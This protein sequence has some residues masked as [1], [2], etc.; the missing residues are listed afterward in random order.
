MQMSKSKNKHIDNLLQDLKE[1]R[2]ELNCLYQVE[3]LLHNEQATLEELFKA[4]I[5]V[6]PSGWQFPE[7]A[8]VEI[9]CQGQTYKSSHYVETPR[10]QCAEIKVQDQVEGKVIVSYRREVSRTGDSY[11]LKEE[12]QLIKAIAERISHIL[13]HRELKKVYHQW[14]EAE[15]KLSKKAVGEWG[16]IVNLL[17]QSNP[18]LFMYLSQ[19]M[20]HYLCWNGIPEARNLMHRAGADITVSDPKQLVDDDP[21]QPQRRETMDNLLAIRDEVFKIAS[22]NLSDD[23]I[24]YHIRRWMEEEKS[25][26]LVEVLENP[27]TSLTDLINAISRFR[28][29]ETEGIKLSPPIDKSLRV[30]LVR[31]FLSEQLEFIRVAKNYIRIKDY[32]DLVKRMIFPTG[33]HGR[34]GGK[35]AGL[36]LATNICHSSTD[37][38]ELF[39]KIKIP[40]TWYITSDGLINFLHYNNL[41]GVYEQKYKEMDEIHVEYPNIIQIFKNAHFPS[42]MI[43]GLSIAVDDLGDT[44]IIVRSSSLLE[45]R[46]GAAFSGKYKSLFLANQGS[47][48]ERL[49]AL[50]DAIAE[51]YASTFG[52]DPIEYR[53]ERGLLDFNEEM[54]IMIQ[55][56]VGTRVGSYYLPTFAGVAFS[57]NEF[58]WS[59]RITREDGLIRL[60]PGLG[61]RA[62]DRVSDDYPILIAPGKPEL[63]VNVTPDEAVR[64]SP[65]NVDIINLET[66]TFET[67]AIPELIKRFGNDIPGIQNLVSVVREGLI[68]KPTSLFNLDF[69]TQQLVVTFEGFF[70]RTDFVRQIGTLLKV[71]QEKIDTPVD[72]EFAHD[73]RQLY[74]LQ[75][76][77]QSYS[78]E[79]QSAPIPKDISTD[80]MVFSANRYI[81]NG[82]V[83]DITHVVYVDPEGYNRMS[84]LS[85]LKKVG[86]AVGKLNKILPKRQ[87][88]LMGPGRW[89]SRGDIKL[90][91]GVT[92]ADINNTAALIEIARKKGNYVP[93]LSFG[94]HFF[95][96]LV[97]AS[98][99]YLPL[100]PD[101]EGI[102][103]DEAFFTRSENILGDILPEYADLSHT[104]R[105]IDVPQSM[106]GNILQILMNAD[107]DEAVGIFDTPGTRIFESM[108]KKGTLPRS[109]DDYW[110]WRLIMAERI[111]AQLDSKRFGIKGIY[112][113]GSSK[114]ATA[115]PGSDI[116]LLIHV[117]GSEQKRKQLLLWLEGWSLALAAQN[118]QRTGYKSD[119]LLDVHLVTDEDI[120]K[121]TTYASK[122]GAITDAARPLQM[123]EIATEDTEQ[124]EGRK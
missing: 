48:E 98:I 103:F 38:K 46:L 95:Q 122:I 99:R 56:V 72:I 33:S 71:L 36:F 10:Q 109:T 54:G 117:D 70:Q 29:L 65:K 102:V 123:K 49:E 14:Q 41:E 28:F 84:E 76:R 77:P 11:F 20:L 52:P 30:S 23:R 15:E 31:R 81:S 32:Y 53:I 22:E 62:V 110:R 24:L 39:E 106:D 9:Q 83:P 37:Y 1:R 47:K 101:D 121:K 3:E 119:G 82:Y 118:Y 105:V 104:L 50:M 75:C 68:Q 88:I 116:D 18:T 115:G 64:Y 25:R 93:E 120:A 45:D 86:R 35:S 96:D 66:N 92:Y 51:V 78:Q 90:G 21:N 80:R 55:E 94:T 97:E 69:E 44:P 91:V 67:I 59:A 108:G 40:K 7:A 100:Y 61:T 19:K 124:T 58:R 6:I 26:F 17:R 8:Q 89:G 73:G 111:A 43:R 87:F 74:L 13:L 42:E 4:I 63:R 114:N 85:E 107:L 60:V 12:S 112:V 79:T 34:L 5:D 57:N 113:F 2:K 27:N 16:V